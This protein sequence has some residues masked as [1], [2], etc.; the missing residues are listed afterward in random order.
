MCEYVADMDRER[1]AD[2]SIGFGSG[3]PLLSV[4]RP[5]AAL[6]NVF[7]TPRKETVSRRTHARIARSKLAP[8]SAGS[9]GGRTGYYGPRELELV[10]YLAADVS[11]RVRV[12]LSIRL[13]EQLQECKKSEWLVGPLR[14]KRQN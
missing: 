4:L 9:A 12:R 10:L 11:D 3:R 5:S 6:K 7:R 1:Q 13:I 2:R 14:A 8:I